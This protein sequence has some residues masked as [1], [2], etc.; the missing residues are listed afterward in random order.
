MNAGD[1]NGLNTWWTAQMFWRLALS[2]E[3]DKNTYVSLT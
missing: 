2:E 1:F 3:V